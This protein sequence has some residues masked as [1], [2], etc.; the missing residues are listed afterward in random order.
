MRRRWKRILLIVV[1]GVLAAVAVPSVLTQKKRATDAGARALARTASTAAETIA[2]EQGGSFASVSLATTGHAC[3][4]TPCLSAATGTQGSYTV[5]ARS[6]SGDT[7]T[8][9][10]NG[11]SIRRSCT[12]RGCR[13]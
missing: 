3:G 5:T 2:T 4:S 12:G 13:W 8:I 10:G 11:I 1:I 9:T 6:P 7:F